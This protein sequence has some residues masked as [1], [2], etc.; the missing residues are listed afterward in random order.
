LKANKDLHTSYLRVSFRL[1]LTDLERL[2]EIFND[3]RDRETA[4]AALLVLFEIPVQACAKGARQMTTFLLTYNA[5]DV[6]ISQISF[7]SV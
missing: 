6:S 2:S 4:T 3:T 5:G 1:T 7:G